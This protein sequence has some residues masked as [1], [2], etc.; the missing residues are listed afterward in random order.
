MKHYARNPGFSRLLMIESVHRA[1]HLGG[2]NSLREW[3]VPGYDMNAVLTQPA[4]S[5]LS[6]ITQPPKSKSSC[7]VFQ[8]IATRCASAGTRRCSSVNRGP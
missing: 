6:P 7:G 2:L 8:K 1:E 5:A 3:S 4:S